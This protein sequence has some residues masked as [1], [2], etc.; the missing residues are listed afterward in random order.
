MALIGGVN[1]Y[2]LRG[3]SHLSDLRGLRAQFTEAIDS[4][5]FRLARQAT[6]KNAGSVVDEAWAKFQANKTTVGPVSAAHR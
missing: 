5:V 3:G 1:S 4:L 6:D 2:V